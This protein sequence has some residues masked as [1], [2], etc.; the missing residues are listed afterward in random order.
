MAAVDRR[1]GMVRRG[2]T[3]A[4]PKPINLP[5]QKLENQGLVSDVEIV[6]RGTFC[7]GSAGRS[8]AASSKNIEG[9]D[10]TSLPPESPGAGDNGTKVQNTLVS[11]DKLQGLA[12]RLSP[13]PSVKSSAPSSSSTACITSGETTIASAIS[14][15]CISDA[16]TDSRSSAASDAKTDSRPPAASDAKTH[17]GCPAASDAGSLP[18][19]V[20]RSF[21]FKSGT[22]P[23][24]TPL[25]FD[26]SRVSAAKVE[27]Q[28]IFSGIPAV[29]SEESDKVPNLQPKQGAHDSNESLPGS[30]D[31]GYFEGFYGNHHTFSRLGMAYSNGPGMAFGPGLHP[32]PSQ[33]DAFYSF[34]GVPY[35]DSTKDKEIVVITMVGNPGFHGGYLPHS[36]YTDQYGRP[37]V[38]GNFPLQFGHFENFAVSG[39]GMPP[40][41]AEMNPMCPGEQGEFVCYNQEYYNDGWV[42]ENSVGEMHRGNGAHSPTSFSTYKSNP[43]LQG[44]TMPKRSGREKFSYRSKR[45]ASKG[46]SAAVFAPER[47]VTLLTKVSQH[48]VV[49]SSLPRK[50]NHVGN[51]QVVGL[52]GSPSFAKNSLEVPSCDPQCKS[53][54]APAKAFNAVRIHEVVDVEKC[55]APDTLESLSTSEMISY[56]AK[57]TGSNNEGSILLSSGN[58][59]LLGNNFEIS[60]SES[61]LTSTSTSTS[62]LTS[63]AHGRTTVRHQDTLPACC[64]ESVCQVPDAPSTNFYSVNGNKARLKCEVRHVTFNADNH[65]MNAAELPQDAALDASTDFTPPT[66]QVNGEKISSTATAASLS[67]EHNQGSM[68]VLLNQKGDRQWRHKGFVAV[69]K[70]GQECFNPKVQE[71][72]VGKKALCPLSISDK[73]RDV[74]SSAGADS[75]PTSTLGGKPVSQC[76]VS[77]SSCAAGSVSGCE[78]SVTSKEMLQGHCTEPD[79][80]PAIKKSKKVH[81]AVTGNCDLDNVADFSS[82]QV[83]GSF[84]KTTMKTIPL[85]SKSAS[86]GFR[87]AW[88]P[89]PATKV[90]RKPDS[91]AIT[92]SKTSGLQVTEPCLVNNRTDPSYM[93]EVSCGDKSIDKFKQQQSRG[94][95]SLEDIQNDSSDRLPISV[96]KQHTS[97]SISATYVT[98]I[99]TNNSTN[100]EEEMEGHK[101]SE[102]LPLK[103]SRVEERGHTWRLVRKQKRQQQVSLASK[104]EEPKHNGGGDMPI[105]EDCCFK[106]SSG[107]S[108]S[109]DAILGVDHKI[110][111][112]T[113]SGKISFTTQGSQVA[114]ALEVKEKSKQN[115][116]ASH[117]SQSML[118]TQLSKSKDLTSKVNQSSKAASG[119]PKQSSRDCQEQRHL[120][121]KNV[122]QRCA[123]PAYSNEKDQP[124]GSLPRPMLVNFR[125]NCMEEGHFNSSWGENYARESSSSLDFPKY[126]KINQNR[127]HFQEGYFGNAHSHLG[128]FQQAWDY[129]GQSMQKKWDA[130]VMHLQEQQR[131][132]TCRSVSKPC[133]GFHTFSDGKFSA[134]NKQY[135]ASGVAWK[136]KQSSVVQ[137]KEESL[138]GGKD[139]PSTLASQKKKTPEEC[140]VSESSSSAPMSLPCGNGQQ[141]R[142]QAF[143]KPASHEREASEVFPPVVNSSSALLCP[144]R[145]TGEQRS[146][147]PASQSKQAFDEG[148]AV[149]SPTCALSFPAG[150]DGQHVSDMASLKPASQMKMGPEDCPLVTSF[151]SAPS[152]SPCGNGQQVGN[153]VKQSYKA[154]L[155]RHSPAVA[156]K[157]T[158]SGEQAVVGTVSQAVVGPVSQPVSSVAIPLRL[159]DTPLTKTVKPHGHH[160]CWRPKAVS[161]IIPA[162]AAFS[163]ERK[164]NDPSAS[165]HV[166]GASKKHTHPLPSSKS[167]ALNDLHVWKNNERHPV[168]TSYG[169]PYSRKEHTHQQKSVGQQAKLHA[170]AAFSLEHQNRTNE[171]FLDREFPR[172]SFTK[173]VKHASPPRRDHQHHAYV[174]KPTQFTGNQHSPVGNRRPFSMK[175]NFSHDDNKKVVHYQ[176]PLSH[177]SMPMEQGNRRPFSTK[178]NFSYDDNRKVVHHQQSLEQGKVRENICIR[179]TGH[180]EGLC[181]SRGDNRPVRRGWFHNGW[182]VADFDRKGWVVK[183]ETTR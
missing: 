32:E 122:P 143:K 18:D 176:Q 160:T 177:T 13:S 111:K 43:N 90:L 63:Q 152:S 22:S 166:E 23:S 124:A 107:C 45:T 40:L 51:G 110:S 98:E 126:Q 24:A 29:G 50:S 89:K 162:K 76:S 163:K 155:E 46:S 164:E 172:A 91:K 167:A 66:E 96:D 149:A 33:H 168:R 116:D 114:T 53:A 97:K 103:N 75:S 64:P 154:A 115:E 183:T 10:S 181:P 180:V 52:S 153:I 19:S 130:K 102:T 140:P 109:S 135:G 56:Q 73:A 121:V 100:L 15:A 178:S 108:I 82:V 94:N 182:K 58:K 35:Y 47:R 128:K 84:K 156:R 8:S 74:L 87:K 137:I 77:L 120:P 144:S 127:H 142:K 80:L 68:P 151:S 169:L 65:I 134:G 44:Y 145:G 175:S 138:E 2:T 69:A 1:M 59:N 158:S 12:E 171:K 93:L 3:P 105:I 131:A 57:C 28:K 54:L 60:A 174:V 26:K 27:E 4:A 81:K 67:H 141:V 118:A 34:L 71:A 157:V 70:L 146:V 139:N 133:E 78:A 25:T 7:W 136:P 49:I 173:E 132:V 95:H 62:M 113:K 179:G 41:S 85:D 119:L 72:V 21:S 125:K 92:T 170:G 14:G 20:A 79:S 48:E 104:P 147:E 31:F 9:T 11:T 129:E 5:S 39:P 83:L 106:P 86:C 55:R 42:N 123:G 150:G 61:S 36:G 37:G 6:P 30:Q 38:Y 16:E 17:S 101:S 165:T 161:G 88:R 99:D 117:V 148:P 159:E 112:A